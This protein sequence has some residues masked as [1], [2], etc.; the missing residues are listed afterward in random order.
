[1]DQVVFATF[2]R[3]YNGAAER[4]QRYTKLLFRREGKHI[5]LNENFRGVLFYAG[6]S[7][8]ATLQP[9]TRYGETDQPGKK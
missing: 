9:I 6:K 7:G 5:S 3:I 1:M 8:K 4:T 2:V